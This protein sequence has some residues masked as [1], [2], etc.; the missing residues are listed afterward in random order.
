MSRLSFYRVGRAT[1][2]AVF[3]LIAVGAI[4]RSLGA[5]MGCPDWPKCFGAW[6]PPSS[7][8]ELPSDYAEQFVE[9]RRLKNERMYGVMEGLGLST[10]MTEE[11][12][13]QYSETKF[14][15]TKAWVEYGNR[16]VGV[17]VGLLIAATLLTSFRLRKES[18]RPFWASLTAFILVV[19][20]GW[21][22]SLVVSTNL[23]P[24]M[25]TVHMVVALVIV[26]LLIYA[27]QPI[28]PKEPALTL[29]LGLRWVLLLGIA[30]MLVQIILG[31]QVREQVDRFAAQY[32][33]QGRGGWVD[34]L[35]LPFYIH[36]SFSILVLLVNGWFLYQLRPLV[37]DHPG[38]AKWAKLLAVGLL[39]TIL[40][41]VILSYLG[42][43]RFVQP[44]HL[45]L[46]AVLLGV[47]WQLWLT[48]RPRRGRT[49]P[50]TR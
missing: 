31:T 17:V 25:I 30:L 49:A 14:N 40:L 23:L 9:S 28:K 8:S 2:V 15:F 10:L 34:Q 41:G 6:L 37:K 39:V 36:R 33:H 38:I 3:L 27:V 42:L 5:G 7:E 19:F 4:V 35:G 43:P 45:L 48:L 46:A 18:W 44:L 50:Q 1:V 21:L 29:P 20:Q 32:N 22:G 47:Q 26:C 12:F 24:G 16:L 11:G 13:D